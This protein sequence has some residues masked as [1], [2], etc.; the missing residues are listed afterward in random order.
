MKLYSTKIIETAEEISARIN[1]NFA[2]SSLK[3]VANSLVKVSN[4]IAKD[5]KKNS[6]FIL[7][8]IFVVLLNILLI[9]FPVI[10]LGF[11]LH[12]FEL[13]TS[14]SDFV[15]GLD[16]FVNAQLYQASSNGTA[17]GSAVSVY[18]N[19]KTGTISDQYTDNN[20]RVKRGFFQIPNT[21]ISLSGGVY[22]QNAG[23]K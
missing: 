18:N 3:N 14:I 12:K 5:V 23:W 17:T 11:I 13:A 9:S 21:Q 6:W 19:M 7:L 4:S 16:A 8:R 20:I 2:D 10:A 22:T 1:E 15:Q